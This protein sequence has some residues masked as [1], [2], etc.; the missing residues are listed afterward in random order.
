MMSGAK[1]PRLRYVLQVTTRERGSSFVQ[2]LLV[3]PV[4]LMIMV[5]GYEIW[6]AQSVRESMRSGTYQA[7]RYLSINP[8]E[9][10]WQSVVRNDFVLPELLNNTLIR[11][12][13]ARQVVVF[14]PAP[15]L[16]CGETFRI[17]SELPWR[18]VIPYVARED[19]MMRVEYEGEVICAP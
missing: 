14:A 19:W 16:E 17:R 18:A 4:F 11:P 7:T 10:N 3:L 1:S 9:S 8:D 12:E 15:I 6:R 13:I 5:G 2:A